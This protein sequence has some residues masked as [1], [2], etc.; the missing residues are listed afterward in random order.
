MKFTDILLKK[1]PL[2]QQHKKT[3]TAKLQAIHGKEYVIDWPGVYMLPRR[4]TMDS[5]SRNFQ[6]H[7]LNNIVYF[8]EQLFK[9]NLSDNPYCSFCKSSYENVI[10]V[11]SECNVI[12]NVWSKLREWLSPELGLP[13]LTPQNAILGILAKDAPFDRLIN[14]IL[15]LFKQGLYQCRNT[16]IPPNF[17]HIK[18]KIRHIQKIEYRIAEDNDCLFS[19]LRKWEKN[20]V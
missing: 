11:F 13:A 8:N 4:V 5:A 1:F 15:I 18:E 14:H 9:M 12:Q 10:H 7:V 6:Y 2:N 16:N 19:H 3:I 20:I 17:Y